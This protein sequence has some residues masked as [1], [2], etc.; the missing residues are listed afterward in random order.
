MTTTESVWD[1]PRPPRLE[2]TPR[3]LRVLHNGITLADSTRG[4]RI[5]ETSHP[6]VYYIPPSDIDLARLTPSR[7]PGSFCEF[8]GI[9]SYWNL[10][11]IA[12]VAWSYTNPTRP[13]AAFKD[14]LAFYATKVDQCFVDQELVTP[15]PGDFYGGWITP[16]IRGP[17]KG[18]PG[19]MNW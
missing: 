2:P 18:S 9:A 8:K 10:G 7:R 14:Y 6:P 19:T 1:Y 16:H 15:Q 11:S 5:L 3:R 13:Y 12:D 17:F 4:L